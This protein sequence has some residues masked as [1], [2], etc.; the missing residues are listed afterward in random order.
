MQK[1]SKSSIFKNP[2]QNCKQPPVLGPPNP[3]LFGPD[4]LKVAPQRAF[5]GLAP[6]F[7]ASEWNFLCA[8]LGPVRSVLGPDRTLE[9]QS[10]CEC[11]FS[12]HVRA[13]QHVFASTNAFSA[14]EWNFLCAL[15]GPVRPVLGPKSVIWAQNAHTSTFLGSDL[16]CNVR[17]ACNVRAHQHVFCH[18]FEFLPQSGNSCTIWAQFWAQV[19][20][21]AALA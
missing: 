14:S 13:H 4:R 2:F 9:V 20:D 17:F 11:P 1:P 21:Q 19:F 18:N 15:L 3:L 6:P 5:L 16:A 7:S 12:C 8:L 10:R